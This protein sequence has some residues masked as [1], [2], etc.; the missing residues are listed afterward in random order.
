MHPSSLGISILL[1]LV[2]EVENRKKADM[3]VHLYDI[4][5]YYSWPN[6]LI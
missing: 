1:L 5:K 6:I 3:E 2:D 4:G